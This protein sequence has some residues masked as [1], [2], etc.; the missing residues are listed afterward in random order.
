M[1]VNKTQYSPQRYQKSSHTKLLFSP[2]SLSL[3]LSL[4][5]P[6]PAKSPKINPSKNA[7]PIHSFIHSHT[8]IITIMNGII[9]HSKEKRGK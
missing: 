3:S 7:N 4:F 6:P 2:L 8:N 1:Q 5:P 9:E